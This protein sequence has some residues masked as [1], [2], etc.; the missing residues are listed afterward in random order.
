MAWGGFGVAAV[1]SARALLRTQPHHTD[2]RLL[3]WTSVREH[4][5]AR[6]KESGD[7]LTSPEL[8]Q[9]CNRDAPR[10]G[11]TSGRSLYRRTDHTARV[12]RG[13]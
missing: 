5:H 8:D 7:M 4:A 9:V 1:L 12:R 11:P 3:D 13:G 10:A 2:S 6:S